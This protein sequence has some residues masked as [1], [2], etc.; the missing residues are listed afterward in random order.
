M[1]DRYFAGKKPLITGRLYIHRKGCPFLPEARI[2]LGSFNSV[3][4]AMESRKIAFGIQEPCP[5][6]CREQLQPVNVKKALTNE[7]PF[8]NACHFENLK[9][10]VPGTY[11]N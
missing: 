11:I 6:C 7:K 3:Y 8:V 2:L 10:C 5:F 1:P 9:V 4:E